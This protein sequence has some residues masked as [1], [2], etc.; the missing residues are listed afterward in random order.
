MKIKSSLFLVV[1]LVGLFVLGIGNHIN[2][3]PKSEELKIWSAWPEKMDPSKPGLQLL[4]TMINEGGKSVNLSA[5][6]IGGPEIFN[7][8]EGC[9]SLRKGVVDMAYTAAAYT[10]GVIPEARCHETDEKQALG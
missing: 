3:A 8:F 4:I 10:T 1:L 7:P 6:Y 9:D 5:K 2:A